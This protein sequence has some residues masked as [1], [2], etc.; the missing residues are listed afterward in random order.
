MPR[1]LRNTLFVMVLGLGACEPAGKKTSAPPAPIEIEML[2]VLPS[3]V[4]DTGEYL[5]EIVSRRNVTLQ[6]QVTGFVRRILVQPGERVTEQQALLEIDAR[7]QAAGVASREAER[8]ANQANLE[9][10]ERT[11]ERTEALFVQGLVSAEELEQVRAEV[12]TNRAT[13]RS[14]AAQVTEQRVELQRFQVRAP[15][16]GVVGDLEVR[17][18]DYVT[19]STPLTTVTASETLEVAVHIP[20]ERARMVT[21]D[22]AIEVLNGDGEV[23]LTTHAYFVAPQANAETQLVEV[24]AQFGNTVGLRPQ[25]KVR[26][27][28]VY[29]ERAA[30]EVPALAVVRQS[31]QAFVYG[32]R[33]KD[34]KTVVARR[35][36]TLGVLGERTYVVEDGLASGDRIAVTSLQALRDDAAVLEKAPSSASS[37]SDAE[38]SA[39]APRG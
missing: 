12:E 33:E 28:V 16:A 22:T 26:T 27:R 14:S 15:V 5:G 6:P 8:R 7:Q 20:A 19:A 23:L 21:P 38:P 24:L 25:E 35:P 9:L 36:V 3:Q 29:G 30:L 11:A 1:S 39:D 37:A 31:G 34:G 32:V 17:V 13:T 10:S 18:G 2:T 4:R